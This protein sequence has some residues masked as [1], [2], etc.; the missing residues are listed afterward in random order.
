[1]QDSSLK[2]KLKSSVLINTSAS[3]Q[4]MI[5]NKPNQSWINKSEL[6]INQVY[7]IYE[8]DKTKRKLSTLKES[9]NVQ[10]QYIYNMQWLSWDYNTEEKAQKHSCVRGSH[11]K[12]HFLCLVIKTSLLEAKSIHPFQVAAQKKIQITFKKKK[13]TIIVTV[14]YQL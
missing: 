12:G 9:L 11:L 4:Q 1:M 7:N 13:I 8:A 3:I 2:I 6:Y 14:T 5:Q 10:M